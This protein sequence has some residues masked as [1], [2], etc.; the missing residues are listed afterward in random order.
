MV[1]VGSGHEQFFADGLLLSLRWGIAIGIAVVIAINANEDQAAL[2]ALFV[3]LTVLALYAAARVQRNRRYGL[4][5]LL[6]ALVTVPV[7]GLLVLVWAI[8]AGATAG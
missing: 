5:M 4:G 7:I 1:D 2:L 6:G 8:W 3:P